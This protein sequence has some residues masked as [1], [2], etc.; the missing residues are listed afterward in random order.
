[1]S[2]LSS[3]KNK[4][5][6]FAKAPDTL[7]EKALRV[8]SIV[9][10]GSSALLSLPVSLPTSVIN[11]LTAVH[12]AADK[13]ESVAV[14]AKWLRYLSVASQ[15]IATVLTWQIAWPLGVL[16][17]LTAIHTFIDNLRDFLDDWKI[18]KSHLA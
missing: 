12:T 2:W 15:W 7:V 11:V 16:N 4:I 1:M 17:A 5:V 18:N 10:Q 14:P 8:V 6:A 9:S 13:A 3:L